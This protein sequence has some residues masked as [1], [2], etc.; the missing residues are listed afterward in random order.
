MKQQKKLFILGVGAQKGGTTW[1]SSK[2]NEL[3][4]YF[5]FGKEGHIWNNVE[6]S[7]INPEKIALFNRK[8]E[9]IQQ[10]ILAC[11]KDSEQY[12]KI[13]GSISLKRN[14]PIAD[15]TPIY[16][17]LNEATLSRIREGLIEQGF[18]VRVLFFARDPVSRAW[19][20][21]RMG[22]KQR[23]RIDP[24]NKKLLLP[25]NAYKS[26]ARTYSTPYQQIRTRYELTL[27]RLFNVFKQDEVKVFFYENLFCMKTYELI[28][29][30]LGLTPANPRFDDV[31]NASPVIGDLPVDIARMVADCYSETYEYMR[32]IY[33]FVDDLW[34]D[35]C[36][37]LK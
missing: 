27:P 32:Q 12:F 29:E 13:C 3:G 10:R 35:S 6:L 26:F 1:W 7:N 2:C 20:M 37:F 4:V 19:S 28:C 11:I 16:C 22:I 23:L 34:S 36:L 17:S 31:R 30:F 33:P 21:H 24:E 14:C 18:A 25:E 15:I 8:K 9:H 5:P